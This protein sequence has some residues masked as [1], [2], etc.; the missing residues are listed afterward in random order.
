M[1]YVKINFSI[2]NNK[3]IFKHRK[4]LNIFFKNINEKN[5]FLLDEDNIKYF[6]NI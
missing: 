3:L 1:N 2:I 6:K 4:I 5:H